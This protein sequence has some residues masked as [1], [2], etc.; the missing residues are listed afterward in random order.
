MTEMQISAVL[1]VLSAALAAI[2]ERTVPYVPKLKIPGS[3]VFSDF[4]HWLFRVMTQGFDTAVATFSAI[5][6]ARFAGSHGWVGPAA[7]WPFWVQVLTAFLLLDLV[8]WVVHF[9]HHKIPFLWK[10]H[11]VHHST[12]D[13][14]WMAAFRRHFVQE[15]IFDGAKVFTVVLMGF[16]AKAAL[17]YFAS[18][19]VVSIPAHSNIRIPFGWLNYVFVT[20]ESHR[21][22][23]SSDPSIRDKNMSLHFALWD[24]VFGTFYCPPGKD[25]GELGVTGYPNYPTNFFVQQ[26]VPFFYDRWAAREN[27]K[28]AGAR[29]SR[30]EPATSIVASES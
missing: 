24:L 4:L 8:H 28:L 2:L 10:V 3:V 15:L 17:V 9:A 7:A 12:V 11:S 21:W 1:L 23:H 18:R 19:V 30:P 22:H 29:D 5:L 25:V 16:D 27:A 6:L 13:M 14:Y 26:L 20:P